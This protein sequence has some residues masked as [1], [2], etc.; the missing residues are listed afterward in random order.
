MSRYIQRFKARNASQ[1]RLALPR[2]L[3]D[4]GMS[5]DLASALTE[6][7]RVT[8]SLTSDGI[9][10]GKYHQ[11]DA[12]VMHLLF[13]TLEPTGYKLKYFKLNLKFAFAPGVAPA[14]AA[15]CLL[16]EDQPV[17][18][19]GV[20][21]VYIEG[22]PRTEARSTGISVDPEVEAAGGG[23]RL[24]SWFRTKE[25]S[26]S[27]RWMFRGSARSDSESHI[28][29][30]AEWLWESN[31]LNPQIEDRGNLYGGVAFRHDGQRL[32]LKCEVEG[33]LCQPKWLRFGT[34]RAEPT[35]WEKSPQVLEQD[36][37]DKVRN[38]E[39]V[40]LCRNRAAVQ[41]MSSPMIS[42]SKC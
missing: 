3:D 35:F 7:V 27:Y 12:A 33:R 31:P 2:V 41:R 6:H 13:R 37:T 29:T 28:M 21:P 25:K 9:T 5:R 32:I 24:G 39:T 34:S 18:L 38:L 19:T 14:N 20:A 36:I 16:Q 10:W 22:R 8:C 30:N 17:P 40:M 23:G 15:V 42:I 1:Q 4:D 26:L 11:R